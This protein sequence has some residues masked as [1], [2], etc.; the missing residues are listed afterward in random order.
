MEDPELYH[1]ALG[2]AG[3][4]YAAQPLTWSNDETV[5]TCRISS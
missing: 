4:P 3:R 2:F 1:R 5:Q